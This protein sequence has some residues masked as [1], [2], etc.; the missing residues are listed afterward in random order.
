MQCIA[1]TEKSIYAFYHS[2]QRGISGRS[3]RNGRWSAEFP[4]AQTAR[5][6]FSVTI[7]NGIFYLFCQDSQGDI[8]L[9]TSN[10]DEDGWSSRVMLKSQ[11]DR[12]HPVALYPMMADKGLSIIYNTP[13]SAIDERNGSL[14]FQRLGDDGQWLPASR[15]DKF[16]PF[17]PSLY[18]VQRLSRDHLLL[19]YQ[20]RTPDNNLGYMEITREEQG[21]YNAF[22]QTPYYV[23]DTS[24]LATDKGVHALYVVK[25]MFSSQLIYRKKAG[26]DFG[27]PIA[28]HEAQRIENC[29]VFFVQNTL[30][31]SFQS[32]GILYMC[33][34]EDNGDTFGRPVRYKAK[35]CQ[36][37]EKAVYISQASQSESQAFMREVYVDHACP[38][39]VQMIPDLYDDFY[40]GPEAGPV[41]EQTPAVERQ[42]VTEESMSLMSQVEG[43][44]RSNSEKDQQI[45]L[46]SRLLQA[47]SQEAQ[48]LT[49]R[50]DALSWSAPTTPIASSA[51]QAQLADENSKPAEPENGES[52]G[53]ASQQEAVGEADQ[54][55]PKKIWQPLSQEEALALDSAPKKP[56]QAQSHEGEDWQDA[57]QQSQERQMGEPVW[58]P[59][60]KD[61]VDSIAPQRPVSERQRYDASA[62]EGRGASQR[63]GSR[64]SS[65]SGQ[66]YDAGDYSQGDGDQD[67]G[68]RYDADDY[69]QGYG[70]QDS[71]QRYD[72]DG[73]GQGYGA[74]G[75]SQRYEAK[76]APKREPPAQEPKRREPEAAPRNPVADYSWSG[77]SLSSKE[78]RA[79][80]EAWA[81]HDDDGYESHG[82]PKSYGSASAASNASTASPSNASPSRAESHNP[83]TYASA[84]SARREEQPEAPRGG[85]AYHTDDE[86]SS[87][88]IYYPKPKR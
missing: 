30:R 4:V 46:L 43:L 85:A 71:G 88:W 35:F 41:V 36:S 1:R 9:A 66:R 42:A 25:S 65:R 45:A 20:K 47:K 87:E 18:Q 55:T 64:G 57:S 31:V 14:V 53:E 2:R 13:S 56:E 79:I 17:G 37:P 69:S 63:Q 28:I 16:Y 44:K 76:P 81:A 72:A 68:Q 77:E 12:F 6:N 49:E 24:F 19:F 58:Y 33:V 60:S 61:E 23:P 34:S 62:S 83:A 73:Y 26:K 11:T 80:F 78:A 67:S 86:D 52:Q 21:A 5:E 48:S 84:S 32:G 22:C 82:D 8:I 27:P 75:S 39:D 59:P 51:Q 74:S 54:N 50:L 3:F 38:W 70:D 15:I 7:E 40:P 29:L 10:V